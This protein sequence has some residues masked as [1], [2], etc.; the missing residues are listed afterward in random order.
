LRLIERVRSAIS[1]ILTF[2][3][4]QIVARGQNANL[5]ADCFLDLLLRLL[6][7]ADGRCARRLF[8]R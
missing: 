2:L 6:D 4:N 1:N 7:A 8:P 5:F 3:A